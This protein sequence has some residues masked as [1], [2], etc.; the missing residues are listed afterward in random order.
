MPCIVCHVKSIQ[1]TNWWRLGKCV[2][3]YTNWKTEL[4]PNVYVDTN[5]RFIIYFNVNLKKFLKWGHNVF[6][7]C[8]VI[9]ERSEM[10][11]FIV[12]LMAFCIRAWICV[13]ET[14]FVFPILFAVWKRST[15][16]AVST[17]W[18][19]LFVWICYAIILC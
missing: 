5:K 13:R 1:N 12:C 3:K 2:K 18:T 14:A 10:N 19:L 6:L 4:L 17:L 15:L 8:I 16:S 9:Q 7:I 11:I